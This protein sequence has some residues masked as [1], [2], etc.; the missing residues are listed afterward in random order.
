MAASSIMPSRDNSPCSR[1]AFSQCFVQIIRSVILL[2]AY[3]HLNLLTNANTCIMQAWEPANGAM[4]HLVVDSNEPLPQS[5]MLTPAVEA[6]TFDIN[7][8]DWTW[9]HDPTTVGSIL[10][11]LVYQTP[12]ADP[13]E[14]RDDRSMPDVPTDMVTSRKLLHATRSQIMG[15]NVAHADSM[16]S[17]NWVSSA[18]SCGGALDLASASM[19]WVVKPTS[20]LTDKALL[21]I[22]G[23]L[24]LHGQ[25]CSQLE[26]RGGLDFD[27]EGLDSVLLYEYTVYVGQHSPAEAVLASRRTATD[28]QLICAAEFRVNDSSPTLHVNLTA[29][30]G[31]HTMGRGHCG[32][33]GHN[34]T[35][36]NHPSI[37]SVICE[38]PSILS[39]PALLDE[40]ASDAPVV[41]TMAGVSGERLLVRG[42]VTVAL[43]SGRYNSIGLGELRLPTGWDISVVCGE[44]IGATPWVGIIGVDVLG[45]F[46]GYDTSD[47]VPS[48]GWPGGVLGPMD[49]LACIIEGG[50]GLNFRPAD[51]V[52]VIDRSWRRI[53]SL[54]S[55]VEFNSRLRHVLV[56]GIQ[57]QDTVG[58]SELIAG[59]ISFYEVQRSVVSACRMH[60]TRSAENGGCVAVHHGTGEPGTTSFNMVNSVCHESY[61]RLRGGCVAAYEW[62]GLLQI[63]GVWL[64]GCVSDRLA[65]IS[66]VCG[67]TSHLRLSITDTVVQNSSASTACGGIGVEYSEAMPQLLWLFQRSAVAFTWAS[68]GYVPYT[69]CDTARVRPATA[70]YSHCSAHSEL[71]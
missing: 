13:A 32:C 22:L 37:R 41:R 71:H 65:A 69:E 23:E 35:I 31:A 21:G 20:N 24:Y 19:R 39:V 25:L 30:A 62:S 43:Q 63:A 28:A 4:L 57:L 33:V 46:M 14:A 49:D 54:D 10:E 1:A 66:T 51:R 68:E 16:M 17:T 7:E 53:H 60:N 50:S 38:C 58:L 6:T 52:L 56:H 34:V 26:F 67:N 45:A 61:A 48:Q 18:M 5:C 47:A 70:V 27:F 36:A 8:W 44:H 11:R 15:S 42:R 40:V 55:D 12:P 2:G 59:G 29:D 3:S 9:L 64:S